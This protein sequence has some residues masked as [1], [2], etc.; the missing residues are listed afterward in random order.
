M[1]MRFETKTS[2]TSVTASEL[3]A[4]VRRA[5]RRWMAAPWA[6]G[7]AAGLYLVIALGAV[8]RED[9]TDLWMN[10][11]RWSRFPFIFLAVLPYI[12]MEDGALGFPPPSAKD[13]L[14]RLARFF[15]L[16][17]ILWATLVFA[18]FFLGSPHVLVAVMGLVLLLWSLG[19]RIASDIVRRRLGFPA[20]AVCSAILTAW[21]IAA[22]F[23]L[24]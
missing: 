16:R 22:V 4:Y 3:V 11:V 17:G 7:A 12:W 2:L 19:Q 18:L 23:P 20:A 10:G 15:A 13:R 6:I 14:S 9:W 24:M 8:L 1:R 21:F 5:D